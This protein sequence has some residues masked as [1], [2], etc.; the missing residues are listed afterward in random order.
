MKTHIL[1]F[2]FLFTGLFTYAATPAELAAITALR[3]KY[4]T[5]S[6]H[7]SSLTGYSY[8][9]IYP[10]LQSDGQFTDSIP[11]EVRITPLLSNTSTQGAVNAFMDPIFNRIWTISENYR[12]KTIPDAEKAKIY[13]AILHYGALE[14]SRPNVSG[15]FHT[16]CFAIPTAAVNIYFCL[17]SSMEQ[18]ENGTVTDSQSVAVLSMLQTLARQS[19]TQPYRNDATDLNVVSVERFRN[20]VWWV[21]GNGLAYRPLLPVSVMMHSADMVNVVS[22]VAKGALNT[23]SQTTINSAFWTEGMTTDGAGWGHGKE[24]LVWG[25][26][27][28]ATNQALSILTELKSTPWVQTMARN[29]VDALLNLIRRSA[30]YYHNGYVP[31]L[32]DR[33]NAVPNRTPYAMK[34]LTVANSLL[35]NFSNALTTAEIAEL[36]QYKTEAATYKVTMTGYP[37][38]N[39]NGSRYFY[40]ND[41]LVK[42]NKD[43]MLIVNMASS[44]V[45]GLESDVTQANGY[46][47]YSCDGTTLF[48]RSGDEY[49]KAIGAMNQSALPG[50]TARQIDNSALVPITLWGGFNSKYNFAAAATSLGTNFAGGFIFEKQD[51]PAA[52]NGTT[53]N[54]ANP[55]IY[56]VQAYK[57]YFM[58]GDLMV[59]MGAG[60]KNMNTALAGSIV[61]SVEQNL[62]KSDLAVDGIAVATLPFNQIL[63]TSTD[64]SSPIKWV[65]NNGFAF[66]VVP[67]YTTG[68]V[69]LTAETRN[70]L[71]Q[72]L[73]PTTNL[74]A[75][76]TTDMM[77]LQIDHG[78]TVTN[79]S[80]VYFVSATGVVPA[81][82]PKI[83]SNTTTLQAAASPDSTTIGAVFYDSTQTLIF[84]SASYKLSSPAALLIERKSKT[85]FAITVTDAK[86]DSTL[87]QMTLTTTLP[88]A[89]AN[90]TNLNGVYTLTFNMPQDSL[91]GSPLTVLVNDLSS[92]T[93]NLITDGSFEATNTGIAAT[94]TYT[95]NN[96]ALTA[97][98]DLYRFANIQDVSSQ[99]GNPTS[100][101]KTVMSGKWYARAGNTS[102]FHRY[103]TTPTTVTLPSLT[104]QGNN[105]LS[106]FCTQNYSYNATTVYTAAQRLPWNNSAVFQLLTLT[107]GHKYQL[108]FWA[109]KGPNTIVAPKNDSL[110]VGLLPAEGTTVSIPLS[111]SAYVGLTAGWQKYTVNFIATTS[112]AT[113]A[114]DFKGALLFGADLYTGYGAS[115]NKTFEY[116]ASIDDVHLFD[117]TALLSE[118]IEPKVERVKFSII[119]KVVRFANPVQELK[120][121]TV[122]GQEVFKAFNVSSVQIPQ[123]GVYILSVDGVNQKIVVSE[124]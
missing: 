13:A 9:T 83:I 120:L 38:G 46:N 50:I 99:T 74:G 110:Y 29:N 4:A 49:V 87:K 35:A 113:L 64:N 85:A 47:L 10:Q 114:A 116:G 53:P 23:V 61:T 39:Y 108:S 48:Q 102:Y 119:G 107:K 7:S 63:K 26:P 25:Y 21:G 58:F 97:L 94:P 56:G 17:L 101:A 28:D 89:G 67:A 122:Y 93:A 24:C 41:D 44:R 22:A 91:C 82:L 78:Q 1:L 105:M 124:F 80:Y 6:Y 76:T 57:G 19:W 65:L 18:I 121:F 60:I 96:F 52:V 115:F 32:Y 66:G 88:I 106:L 117:Q 68:E 70:T 33:V 54:S 92:A 16:S 72:K 40:N 86:M 84:N 8:A 75:E 51:A 112:D 123:S 69:K 3:T 62:R 90:V 55:R 98:L 36:N 100:A 103:V 43:Y 118:S 77:Q 59:A 5:T 20:H 81:K 111:G 2:L 109:R 73:S 37:D 42:K 104:V 95:L 30:F 12:N 79:G 11:G 31:P 71:W 15:R 27:F 45:S 14:T 34:A